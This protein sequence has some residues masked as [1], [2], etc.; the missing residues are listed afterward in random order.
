MVLGVVA[1]LMPVSHLLGFFTQRSDI[2][3]TP[4]E[5][6]VPLVESGDRV[7]IFVRDQLL[8]RQLEAGRLQV[9]TDQGPR[10]LAASEVVLRFNNHDRVQA[11]QIP[12]LLVAA[13]VSGVAVAML[14]W[15]MLALWPSRRPDR[16]Q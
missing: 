3:W 9:T 4:K 2:W 15:G 13:F 6:A 1:L 10:A 8:Q 16:E 12:G 7:E 5:L 14:G 11:E